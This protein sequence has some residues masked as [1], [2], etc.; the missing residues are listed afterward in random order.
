MNFNRQC[1]ICKSTQI[2][3]KK[4]YTFVIPKNSLK[5][6]EVIKKEN[7][8][9]SV[10][11]CKKCGN[12]YLYPRFTEEEYSIIFSSKNKPYLPASVLKQTLGRAYLNFNFLIQFFNYNSK[13][14]PKVLD[15]GG[16]AG[17][18][19]IPFLKKCDCYLI[20]YFKYNLLKNIQY[21]GRNL[22]NVI[23]KFKFDI[24]MALRVFEHVNDPLNLLKDLTQVLS[25]NGIIYVQVPLGCLREWKSL[26]T[27]FRHINFFSEQSLYNCFRIAS[28]DIIYLKTKYHKIGGNPGWKIDII[29]IKSR[30]SRK[31]KKIRFYTTAQQ[32][33]LKYIYYLPY[34]IRNKKFKLKE[35]KKI[36]KLGR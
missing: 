7:F 22:N 32:Q 3:K 28:L 14:L 23:N 13:I 35:I 24:I 36:I 18:M 16:A 20:D 25:E 33:N 4:R 11:F 21:L 9:F 29:G 6:T 1:P 31:H 19:L 17:Y 15:Y 5:I 12:L 26:D 10:D 2:I 34:F 8:L 30:E 27:P